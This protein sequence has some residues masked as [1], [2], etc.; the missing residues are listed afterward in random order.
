MSDSVEAAVFF[1]PPGCRQIEGMVRRIIK[2]KLNDGQLDEAPLTL[3][4]LDKIG[5]TFVHILSGIFHHRIE[6]PE[7]ELRADLEREEQIC[8]CW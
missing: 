2:E 8:R 6:Y 3:R 4:D 1:V 7:R 5:D